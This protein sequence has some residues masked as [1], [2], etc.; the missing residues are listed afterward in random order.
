MDKRMRSYRN[1][2]QKIIILFVVLFFTL[3]S[4]KQS[5]FD[6]ITNGNI[7]YWSRYNPG[8]IMEYSKKDSTMKYLNEDWTYMT[9]P[10]FEAIHGIKFRITNDT[11]FHY[12]DNKKGVVI[13][14][15]TVS[16]VSYSKNTLIFRNNQGEIVVWKRRKKN[17]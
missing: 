4:C 14:F 10:T 3:A 13:T 16:I 2:S 5:C 9:R 8:I 11:L 1:S 12:I 17:M 15:D 6:V 7:A